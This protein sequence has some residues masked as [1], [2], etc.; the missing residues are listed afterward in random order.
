MYNNI[1]VVN[2]MQIGDLILT[3]PILRTLRTNFPKAHIT[4][5]AD[6]RFADL[7]VGNK[8]INEC[9]FMDK[10]GEDKGFPK[11]VAFLQKIRSRH[12]DLV[13]NFHRNERAS[14][15]AAFSGAKTIV[16]YSKPFFAWFF[17]KVLPNDK[18][19]MHQIHS[20]FNVLKAVGIEK[21]DDGGLEIFPTKEAKVRGGKLWR[22]NFGDKDK[23]IA[24][25]IGASWESKRWL[26]EY[27]ARCADEL[28]DRGY[29]IAFFGGTMDESLV[30][31]CVAMMRKGNEAKI[32]TGAVTLGELAVM[33]NEC[34][35]MVTTDSGPMHI[36]VAM[37]LPIVTMFGSSPV[38]GFYPYDSKDVLI[39]TP[40]MC[41]PC[42]KHV[43]PKSGDGR[44]EC[45]KRM[46]PDTVMKY[47]L[48]LL[49]QYGGKKA[50]KLPS[51]Y[52]EYQ[53]RVIELP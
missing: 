40:A 41:H 17:T 22:K 44:M 14:A 45:M 19:I 39:K 27:F 15:V 9:M 52:G 21:I 36:G 5:A 18:A 1:L 13:L 3:T 42:G 6:K 20:H 31:D 16:G 47:A 51:H 34:S 38:P 33:L 43:C 11:F 50:K 53:C 28:I 46:P 4:L 25:N 7:V 29:K 32:F 30:H 8:Y 49:D 24:F 35:L 10:R 2:F 37:N 12:F 23:V 48:E 26:P